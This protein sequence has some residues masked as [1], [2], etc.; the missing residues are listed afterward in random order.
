MAV[1]AD[2][3]GFDDDRGGVQQPAA[4]SSE[5]PFAK[6]RLPDGRF[7]DGWWQTLKTVSGQKP[8]SD[9]AEQLE[10]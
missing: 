6:W 2:A 3:S 7:T 5:D 1:Q 9:T 10:V 8:P 4:D